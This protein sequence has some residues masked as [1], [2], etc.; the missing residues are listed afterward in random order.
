MESKRFVMYLQ[1]THSEVTGSGHFNNVVFPNK[2]N[3]HFLVDCGSF[4]E[5]NS[6]KNLILHF[7]LIQRN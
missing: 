1:D 3:T 7:H 5:K 4:L 6:V 2:E